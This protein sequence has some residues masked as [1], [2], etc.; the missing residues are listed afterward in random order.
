VETHNAR[1][2]RKLD[3]F[4]RQHI[5]THG[6]ARPDGRLDVSEH[7]DLGPA[8]AGS[9]K[10]LRSRVDDQFFRVPGSRGTAPGGD[11]GRCCDGRRFEGS[12]RD[13]VRSRPGGA[14]GTPISRRARTSRH[15]HWHSGSERA[16]SG[17]ECP[18]LQSLVEAR[19]ELG[20]TIA[21]QEPC[22]DVCASKVTGD[23][24]RL[25]SDPRR[26]WMN[27][28]T[29]DPDSPAA[30]LDEEQYREALDQHCVDM[31]NVRRH[32]ARRL[33]TQELTPGGACLRGAGPRPWSFRTRAMVLVASRTPSLASS[34]W[35]RR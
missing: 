4:F 23:V 21:D 8:D 22:G 6:S 3:L 35:I 29:G 2:V 1:S 19:H 13:A 20:V 5:C 26:V 11:G 30:E 14:R 12:V 28:H 18:R 16:C 32:D 17:S 15:E 24:P 33:R 27:G 9:P 34:P 25:L 7:D 31:E 10:L